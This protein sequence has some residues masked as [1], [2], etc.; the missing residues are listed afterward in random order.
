MT[1]QILNNKQIQN[2]FDTIQKIAGGDFS[3]RAK[4]SK[5]QNVFDAFATGI[6]MLAEEIEARD[7]EKDDQAEALL[8]ILEDVNEAK[9]EAE[10][11]KEALEKSEEKY[12]DLVE[13]ANDV[14][15]STDEN[16]IINYLS[17]SIIHFTGYKPEEL[18][19]KSITEYIHEDDLPN[20]LETFQGKFAGNL[21]ANEYRIICKNGKIKWIRS[22]SK[23][24][25]N[26]GKVMGLHGILND[27]T[28]K[29]QAENELKDSEEKLEILFEFAPDA[30]FLCDL[31]GN[32][33]K[34]NLATEKLIGYPKN[35]FIGK[36]MFELKVFTKDQV[37]KTKKLL[38]D[39][40]KGKPTG[41]EEF[42]IV[43]SDKTI[44]PVEVRTFP[45]KIKDQD[46]IL[47]IARDITDRKKWQD[48]LEKSF[49]ITKATLE[50]T[51]EGIFVVDSNNDIVVYNQRFMEMWGIPNKLMKTRDN[52]K[53]Q[54]FMIEHIIEKKSFKNII[55]K[56]NKNKANEYS[57]SLKLKD[58]RIFEF[59]SKPQFVG[60]EIVGRVWSFS[61]ITERKLAEEA[62]KT[63]EEK[64]RSLVSNLTDVII[65]VD[66][67]M[68]F[69]YVSPQIEDVFGFKS[70]EIIGTNAFDFVHPDD[71]ALA[72]GAFEKAIEMGQVFQFEFKT[73][74]K[75]GHYV[76]VF[77]TG[78]I[79]EESED[80]KIV[81]LVRDITERKRLEREIKRYTEHLED[82]V[83][84]RTNELIQT[85][86]MAALGQLVAGVAHEINN[87]L[88]FLNSNTE[89]IEEY[90]NDF[91]TDI[92]E[93]N[94]NPTI[95]VIK[96]L[97]Q[98][99]ITGI[100]RIATITKSLK[101]FAMPDKGEKV[102]ADINQGIRDTLLI[103]YNQFKHRINLHEEYGD[104]PKIKC[105]IGQLNQVFMNL[106]LNA[107]QAMD[108]GD[109]WIKTW[110][111]NFN[112][113][114]EIRD[115]GSG[116]PE[117]ALNKIFDPFYTTKHE[118]TGLGLS[119]VYRIIKDHNGEIKVS[120]N[121]GEGT[122]MVISLPLEE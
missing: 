20:L 16:G 121:I 38:T 95:D 7:R 77:G 107:S 26:D 93:N 42:N 30:I 85:E 110:N 29:K 88:G 31:N 116:I 94:S 73:V 46:I 80:F 72:L 10:K 18:I 14:I 1:E 32:L 101:R 57:E 84:K 122:R 89:L 70:E 113:Y 52:N 43:R 12:R 50:S 105:K 9:K 44:I 56:L 37:K 11:I 86:K 47:G 5:E 64:F 115:N 34:G 69:T 119:L 21:K 98:T 48:E 15:Y 55:N 51:D 40:I 75:D 92:H 8:N 62:L 60:N 120:S 49:S 13:N 102:Q 100:D 6:N 112:V 79:V 66:S 25:E 83:Q 39:N 96:D 58:N 27:I 4:I 45:V 118:G 91:K 114:I 24:I 67:N 71:Q 59:S 74:H 41:P 109:I 103:L 17:P 78:R 2:I 87:P 81:G 63:S 23:P 68:E 35:E 76:E 28:E 53:V 82:E 90:M 3:A 54:K 108:D 97:L 61:D 65:E 22:S 104:I 111:D 36:N 99:N 117:K 106:F 19:G 33:I